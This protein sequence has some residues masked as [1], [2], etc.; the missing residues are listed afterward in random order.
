MTDVV[1]SQI[2]ANDPG[3]LVLDL[4]E[5]RLGANFLDLVPAAVYACDA[6]GR[7]LLFNRRA[8][9]LWGREPALNDPA[10][11]FCGAH[12]LYRL[13]GGPLPHQDCPMANVLRTGVPVRDQEVV[14]EHPDGRRAVALVNIDPL[15]DQAG[16]LVGAVNCFHDITSRKRTEQLQLRARNEVDALTKKL[17]QERD[18]SKALLDALPAAIYTTD[19]E[20]RVTYFN[21]AAARLWGCRPELGKAEFCGS[22]KLYWP[23]GTPMAHDECPM[24]RALREQ[25]S[26][27]GERAIAERPDGTRIQF[28]PFPTPLFDDAGNLIGAVNLLVD[29]AEQQQFEEVRQRLAAVVESST[30]AI[31]SK[32]LDGIISSWNKGAE[33]V[34]GYKAEEVIGRSILLLIPAHMH[35]EETEILRQLRR[36]ERIE[37][38]ETIR[39]RKD[40]TLIDVSLSVAP[41][42]GSYGDVIGASKIARDIT[43]RKKAEARQDLLSNELQHRTRNIFSVVLSVVTRSFDGKR[44]V[45]AAKVAVLQRLHSLSQTH[46]MLIV[47]D[48]RGANLRDVVNAEMDPYSDRIVVEGPSIDLNARAAQDFA[49]AI[50]ELATNAAKY[51]ALSN[52]SGKV[53]IDWSVSDAGGENRFKFRWSEQGGPPVRPPRKKGFGSSVVIRVMATHTDSPPVIE[54]AADGLRYE[55]S[56]PLDRI[57]MDESVARDQD[58]LPNGVAPARKVFQG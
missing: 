17:G 28:I 30:D 24:A 1:V 6:E 36:G 9:E 47:N 11:R 27:R 14:I 32:N 19:A 7:I 51:G 2:R 53:L 5:A 44:N 45:T 34:F 42:Y 56:G 25:R 41:L 37:H 33:R 10:D 43:E 48:W 16:N 57:A 38:Y 20:G 15:L 54:F 50:H 31:V 40:G 58:L 13:D 39:R 49:L 35:D 52:G 55:L 12:R 18:Q 22:W 8:A 46:E 26:I 3:L 4:A 23:D 21:S 29:A